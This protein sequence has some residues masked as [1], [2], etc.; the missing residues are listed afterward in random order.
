MKVI[1]YYLPQFHRIRENDKWWGNGFTEWTFTRKAKPLFPGHYQPRQPYRSQYY[2]LTD[3]SV[4]EQQ[5]YLAKKYGVYGFCYYHY[6]FQGRRLLERPFNEVLQ[7]GKPDFP[8]CLCWANHDW[9]KWNEPGKAA[10][11]KLLLRQEY[12]EEAEWKEHF[13]Y[14][15]SCFKDSRYIRYK[16]KPIFVIHNSA[17]IPACAEKLNYWQRLARENGLKGI[18][19]IE[20]INAFYDADIPGF[21]A[22][23]VLEPNYTMRLDLGN[24]RRFTEVNDPN[25]LSGRALK[26]FDYDEVWKRILERKIKRKGKSIILGAFNDW[27]NS[28]RRGYSGM[29]LR[30]A[31][32]EKFGAYMSAAIKRA[33]A[34]FHPDFIFFNAWN[35]WG[36]GAYLEADKKYGFRY[37]EEL[38]KA[39]DANN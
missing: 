36:E 14:L 33:K 35:E 25:P 6:W 26:M 1:A 21:D 17:G 12:G 15:L 29:V 16:G 18:Y 9:I 34:S 23:V 20:T 8:F 38:K 30:N 28:P 32:P 5:A 22:T 4:R 13:D 2:D 39:L 3:P 11:D 7:S 19:F 10:K 37:L 31:S 27:D 24:K